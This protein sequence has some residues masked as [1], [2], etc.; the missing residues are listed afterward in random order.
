MAEVCGHGRLFGPIFICTGATA[1]L[2]W[3]RVF[4]RQSSIE[5]NG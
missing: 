4:V 3:R 2:D 5:Q 1:V